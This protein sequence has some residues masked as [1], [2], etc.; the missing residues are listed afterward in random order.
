M[1]LP[2]RVDPAAG[3]SLQSQIAEQIRQLILDGRL[4]PRTR[5]PA[6][7]ELAQD[8]DVSRN[9][10]IGAF[11]RLTA[12]GLLQTREPIGTFVAESVPI[13]APS[14]QVL[15]HAGSDE[16]TRH[17]ARARI[18]QRLQFHDES[19]QVL[20]P[21]ARQLSFDFWVGRPD[22]RVFPMRV[23]QSLLVRMLRGSA[24]HLC[25]YGDPQGVLELR[26]AVAVHVGATRGIATDASRVLITNG[27]QE[28]L[29]LLAWLLVRRGVDVAV[30]NPCYRGAARVFAGHGGVLRPVPVD[31]E[32]L[33][34]TRL[35][36]SAA[37]AYVTPS[38]QYPLGATLSLR[39]RQA[40]LAW[41]EDSGSYIAEDDYDCDFFYDGAPLPA[42]KS[43]DRNDQ[44]IYLGTFSKSLG[45]G[46]RIGYMV[47]PAELCEPARHA[48]ALLNNCQPWLE[49]AALAA[50]IHEGGFA[51]HARRLR[52]LYTLRRNHLCAA[53]AHGLPEWQIDGRGGGMHLVVHLPA[54]GPDAQSVESMARARGVGVYG[55]ENGNAQLFPADAGDP[56]HRVLLLGYAALTEAEISEA[57]LRLRQVVRALDVNS[58]VEAAQGLAVGAAAGAISNTEKPPS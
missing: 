24:V 53:L 16:T 11:A 30:E 6:S 5:M 37:L 44:V 38:H 36:R 13:P 47:L 18:R 15:P 57:V 7:R 48:K 39:R 14:P 19:H 49:Q 1:Q 40:L 34:C 8:L 12:E 41:A 32:G 52:Q 27:I 55:V 42:L 50:F 17:G 21:H 54:D 46:L 9:T 4:A 43:L 25:E 26:E 2:I 20:A 31:E 29:N 23:W 10:V 58:A 22:A 35:P 3:K 51:E 56:L 33:V 28:G 45:A